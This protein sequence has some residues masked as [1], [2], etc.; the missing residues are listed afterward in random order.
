MTA[1]LEVRGLTV[2]FGPVAAVTDVDLDL[3][4]GS[5]T[6]LIGP[7]GA[8]KTTVID[9]LT[10]FVPAASGRISLNG[11]A[12]ERLP[13]HA[14]ARLGLGRTFQSLELFEDLTVGE[15]LL[16]AAEASG[17]TVDWVDQMGG[18]GPT[19]D[20]LPSQLSNA[21]RRLV[22]LTRAVAGQPTVLLLDEP[23][24]GLDP[25]GRHALGRRLRW[26]ADDGAAVL[27]VDHDLDLV[28]DV[29]D[30]VTVLDRGRVVAAGP[31]A[32]LR[33]DPRVRAV[34]LGAEPAAA[35][36]A[37][38]PT[39]TAAPGPPALTVEGLSAG[40]GPTEVVHHVDLTVG[41]AEMVALLGLNGAGKTT[42]VLG[43]AGALARTAGEVR[44]G[45]TAVPPGR[46][47]AAAR[48]GL[49][50]VPQERSLFT[51]L[52]VVE[53]L[54]LAVAGGRRALATET[55]RAVERFPALAELLGRRAGLLS[56]G[57]QRMV[58]LARALARHP[59]VL[60]VDELSLGLGPRVVADLGRVLRQVVDEEGTAVLLVEQH[61]DVAVALAARAYVMERGRIVAEGPAAEI[62]TGTGLFNP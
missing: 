43:I 1:G 3:R 49:A 16:V 37:A 61:L 26:L 38:T 12:V 40:Y 17:N 62:A 21:Q 57:E 20:L 9:A 23:A 54:R 15:N 4:P 59:Q 35:T 13:A 29:C 46:P 34:Y 47:H 56:G 32:T 42:T 25:A 10:G 52:S 30:E 19:V 44:V 11:R 5:V 48:R 33:A 14:R 18:L 27:L 55:A 6:G 45:G 24:A 7:N 8:G 2:R 51:Q 31:P 60:L 28:L 39:E 41:R 22:A 36:A 50:C 53:N 58:A